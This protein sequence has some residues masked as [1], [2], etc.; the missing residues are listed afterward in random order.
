MKRFSLIEL[1]V[2]VAIIGVLASFVLPALGK[3]RNTSR[4]ATCINNLRQLNTSM[5]IY[6]DDND[7]FVI[8]AAV[9][10]SLTFS[11]QL[12]DDYSVSSS[13][14]SC[15]MD[16]VTRTEPKDPRSYSMNTGSSTTFSGTATPDPDNECDGPT[17]MATYNN[18][19]YNNIASDTLLVLENWENIN[20]QHDW[21]RSD[22]T[23]AYYSYLMNWTDR[24]AQFHDGRPNFS[25]IDG[26]VQT[27]VF[28]SFAQEMFTRIQD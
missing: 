25:L 13:T 27:R 7:S 26:S 9:N 8:T 12:A 11:K 20:E 23:W 19:S 15:S 17:R 24:P 10:G 28:N 5:Y 21:A 4:K 6:S 3:A 18:I 14:F 1:L 22:T 2:V 16:D